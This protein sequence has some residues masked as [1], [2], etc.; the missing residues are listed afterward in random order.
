[1]KIIKIFSKVYKSINITLHNYDNSLIVAML[2]V[3]LTLALALA[4]HSTRFV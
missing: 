3:A 2:F 4:E 1:M